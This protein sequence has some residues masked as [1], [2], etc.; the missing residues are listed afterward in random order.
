MQCACKPVLVRIAYN[1]SDQDYNNE[2]SQ[3]KS[4]HLNYVSLF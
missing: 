3:M 2:V 4:L 1:Y